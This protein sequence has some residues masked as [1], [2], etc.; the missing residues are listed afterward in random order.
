MSTHTGHQ[1]DT[2]TVPSPYRQGQLSSNAHWI[3]GSIYAGL[4]LVGFGFGVW[5]G[6]AKPKPTETAE[7][8]KDADKE[9]PAPKPAVVTPPV[10]NVNPNPSP[11]VEPKKEPAPK[12]KE[13]EPKIKEPEPK[14]KEPEPKPKPKEPEVKKPDRVVLFK[15]VQ[16]ILRAYCNDCH[17]GST[18]KPK[19]GVDLTSLA[20]ILKSKGPPLVPG[21]PTDSTLY[22]STKS[23]D[24]PPD[25]KK[26]PDAKEL[27]LLYDWIAGGAGAAPAADRPAPDRSSQGGIDAR[28]RTGVSSAESDCHRLTEGLL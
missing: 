2:D 4:A 23:G 16:P 1:F 27:Q 7:A 28:R 21:K 24:M 5:A 20:K 3:F 8:K 26:G 18:G 10:S 15:E 17:G 11:V 14:P 19:G 13:P 9:K 12:A 6:A 25:G 22:S